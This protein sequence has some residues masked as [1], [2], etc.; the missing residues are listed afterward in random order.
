MLGFPRPTEEPLKVESMLLRLCSSFADHH[1]YLPLLLTILFLL[2][3][4]LIQLMYFGSLMV[5]RI[6]V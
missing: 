2:P 1:L 5:G 3:L 6:W 4:I